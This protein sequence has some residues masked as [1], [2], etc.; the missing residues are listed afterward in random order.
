MSWCSHNTIEN[1]EQRQ[2]VRRVLNS[3]YMVYVKKKTKTLQ[4]IERV[5]NTQKQLLPFD[6]IL[7]CDL[8]LKLV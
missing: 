3:T 8:L 5:Q 7:L 4:E 1:L 6:Q 2:R